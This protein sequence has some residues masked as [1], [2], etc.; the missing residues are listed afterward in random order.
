MDTPPLGRSLIK[1][2]FKMLVAIC[3][4]S[5]VAI[6]RLSSFGRSSRSV[7]FLRPFGRILPRFSQVAFHSFRVLDREQMSSRA[8]S[9]TSSGLCS[10]A[11]AAD[12]RCA[13]ALSEPV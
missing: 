1:K 5:V 6:G 11:S 2:Q 12:G 9:P 3:I 7:D 4:R 8:R 13:A 10:A